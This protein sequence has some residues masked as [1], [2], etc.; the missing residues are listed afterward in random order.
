MSPLAA[1]PDLR[2]PGGP[3]AASAPAL[4]AHAASAALAAVLVAYAVGVELSA[5]YGAVIDVSAA[6][7]STLAYIKRANRV[8]AIASFDPALLDQWPQWQRGY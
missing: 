8:P 7:R 1:T 3:S 4:L 2:R 5:Q 6:A